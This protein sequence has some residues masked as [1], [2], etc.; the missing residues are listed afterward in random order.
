MAAVGSTTSKRSTLWIPGSYIHANGFT[1]QIKLSTL[2]VYNRLPTLWHRDQW[3]GNQNDISSTL[4]DF[5][6]GLSS[7]W[8]KVSTEEGKIVLEHDKE[9]DYQVYL[10]P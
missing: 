7:Q 4:F 5:G 6:V 9:K 10:F 8:V 2:C 1:D 3:G